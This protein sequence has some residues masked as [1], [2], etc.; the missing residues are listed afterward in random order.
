MGF[1][2]VYGPVRVVG[3]YGVD[4][5]FVFGQR[6][7]FLTG[8]VQKRVVIIAQPAQHRGRCRGNYRVAQTFGNRRVKPHVGFD[9]G[10]AF[11]VIRQM[12]ALV[13]HDLA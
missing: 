9:E 1:H 6:H 3:R 7:V 4:D 8:P 10:A 13:T 2:L 11:T 12:V 5:P